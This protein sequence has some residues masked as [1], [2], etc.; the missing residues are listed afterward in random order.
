MCMYVSD[1]LLHFRSTILAQPCLSRPPCSLLSLSLIAYLHTHT[2]AHTYTH[3]FFTLYPHTGTRG[4]HTLHT[5]AHIDPFLAISVHKVFATA[6]LTPAV[7]RESVL[8][9]RRI[10]TK[11][12]RRT[13]V[14]GP[15]SSLTLV[16]IGLVAYISLGRI[17][18]WGAAIM[19]LTR[20]CCQCY[21]Y[22]ST[23]IYLPLLSCV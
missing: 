20:H 1:F 23:Y 18:P 5:R 8:E 12:E 6:R 3:T 7:D 15:F 11:T 2:H 10:K 21:Y 13:N 19:L 22:Y 14:S 9:A 17:A 4:S 16:E